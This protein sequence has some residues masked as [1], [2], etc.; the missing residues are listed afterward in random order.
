[1]NVTLWIVI[2]AIALSCVCDTIN[3]IG[4]KISTSRVGID[5]VGLST[6]WRFAL[7]MLTSPLAWISI[8]VSFVSLFLFVF[9]LSLADLSFAFSLDSLHH[10]FVPLTAKVLLKEKVGRLR[11]AG[12]VLIILGAVLVSITG[13]T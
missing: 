9:A 5:V 3:Q 1:M 10:V 11:G 4:L 12:I 2:G 6:L 13:A 8:A 7:G